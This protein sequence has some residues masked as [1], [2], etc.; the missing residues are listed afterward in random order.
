M[1]VVTVGGFCEISDLKKDDLLEVI[2]DYSHVGGGVRLG[3]GLFQE[4][5]PTCDLLYFRRQL[6][7]QVRYWS[8]VTIKEIRLLA[9]DAS[10]A[11]DLLSPFALLYSNDWEDIKNKI[12]R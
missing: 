3:L 10:L 5:N 11:F 1:R 4:F 9:R 8:L 6:D 12:K 7:R 2:L